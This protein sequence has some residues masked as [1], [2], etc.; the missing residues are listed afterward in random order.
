MEIM[1]L[2]K[3][4]KEATI[5]LSA[6]ELVKLTNVLYHATEEDKNNLYYQVH[7]DLLMARDLCQYGHIDKFCLSE[8][9][10]CRDQIK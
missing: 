2:S 8:I 3:E 10:K 4:K 6:D 7:S 5:R 1:Q 9:N